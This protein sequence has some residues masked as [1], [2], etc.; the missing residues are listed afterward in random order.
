SDLGVMTA[1]GRLMPRLLLVG[2]NAER[3]QALAQQYAPAEWT[4]DVDAALAREDFSVFFDAAAND[5]RP[6]L[7]RRAIEAGKHVLA[8]KPVVRSFKEGL[9]LLEMLNDSPVRHGAVEDKLYLPGL[10]RLASLVREGRFGRI[11]SFE[12]E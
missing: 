9:Q 6:Q 1:R 3:L 12:L 8:E 11:L 5:L 2:R 10:S 4:T 7:L